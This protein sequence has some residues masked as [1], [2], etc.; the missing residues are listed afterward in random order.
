MDEGMR[1]GWRCFPATGV[2]G[3]VLARTLPAGPDTRPL[4]LIISSRPAVSPP[5][6]SLFWVLP[7]G[8]ERGAK[9]LSCNGYMSGL[10]KQELGGPGGP[11]WETG[12]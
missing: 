2:E 5:A 6:P 11:T 9:P 8:Q 7:K 12:A 1:N 3:A 10:K 4:E